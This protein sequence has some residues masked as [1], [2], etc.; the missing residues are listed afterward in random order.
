MNPWKQSRQTKLGYATIEIVQV[1]DLYE[2]QVRITNFITIEPLIVNTRPDEVKFVATE[3]FG[4][5]RCAFHWAY[6]LKQSINDDYAGFTRVGNDLIESRPKKGQSPIT[7]TI[8]QVIKSVRNNYDNF[9][10]GRTSTSKGDSI[11]VSQV[12][13]STLSSDEQAM[14]L[15]LMT[16][17]KGMVSNG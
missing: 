13:L 1:Q 12:K 10:L 17:A 14:L 3:T 5:A 15:A 2:A 16:K 7:M 9:T 8:E 4:D 6:G 11:S